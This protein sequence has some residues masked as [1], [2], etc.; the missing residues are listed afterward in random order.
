LKLSP[1]HIISALTTLCFLSM[2]AQ[3]KEL[4]IAVGWTKPPYVI[5]NDNSGFELDLVRAVLRSIGHDIIPIYVPFGRSATMLLQGQVDM[6]LTINQRLIDRP[7][8]LS[9]VY[10]VY[11]NVAI[12]LKS[13]KLTISS[14]DDLSN[15]S[16][17][18]FQ[19]ATIVLGEEF[20]QTVKLSRLY[21][22]L[23]EQK[24]QTEMLLLG[25][26]DV[27]VMDINIFIHFSR[28]LTGVSQLD[29]VNIHPVF[30]PSPYHVAFNDL[31]LKQ[32]FNVAL[33][34]FIQTQAYTDLVNRYEFYQS[35]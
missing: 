16:I 25:N 32:Q 34:E 29:K 1:T 10:I 35:N 20:S 33:A 31:A 12:S 28:E 19:N 2:S 7:E 26:T 17:V 4:D 23:P 24:R 15:Y 30:P 22:E 13:K 27:V 11:Q 18:A 21:T 14:I 6:A 3:G 8:L 5:S 9:D